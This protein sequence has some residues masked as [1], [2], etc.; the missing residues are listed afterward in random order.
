MFTCHD[1]LARIGGVRYAEDLID[2]WVKSKTEQTYTWYLSIAHSISKSST[3]FDWDSI[4]NFKKNF[5]QSKAY[6]KYLANHPNHDSDLQ[7][8]LSRVQASAFF[9]ENDIKSMTD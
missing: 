6:Q 5:R 1:T 7:E 2:Y 9:E 3:K 8:M 4:K